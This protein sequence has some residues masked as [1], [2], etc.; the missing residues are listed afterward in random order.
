MWDDYQSAATDFFLDVR[1]PSFFAA[2]SSSELT[3]LFSVYLSSS[4]LLVE[5][6][7]TG[8]LGRLLIE[9]NKL[10]P[11]FSNRQPSSMNKYISTTFR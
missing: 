10:F 11:V 5:N 4:N 6:V 2:A 1:V 9:I 8:Y 7:T 3:I